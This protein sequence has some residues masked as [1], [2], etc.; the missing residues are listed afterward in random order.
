MEEILYW[1]T[2]LLIIY[3]ILIKF[4]TKPLYLILFPKA[5]LV[6]GN[7]VIVKLG[8]FNLS[9]KVVFIRGVNVYLLSTDNLQQILLIHDGLFWMFSLRPYR[10]VRKSFDF[11]PRDRV[12]EIDAS[13][14]KARMEIVHDPI[15][16][17]RTKIIPLIR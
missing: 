13:F 10:Y 4:R 16:R 9:L 8:L 2:V 1:I 12:G 5:G 6:N 3:L 11:R 15:E 17:P 14:T 7:K